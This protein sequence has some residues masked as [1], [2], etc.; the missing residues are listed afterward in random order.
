MTLKKIA[1]RRY[2]D[3]MYLNIY[4]PESQRDDQ[5]LQSCVFLE[6]ATPTTSNEDEECTIAVFRDHNCLQKNA[7]ILKLTHLRRHLPY[8]NLKVPFLKSP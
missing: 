5:P 8:G 7:N 1:L 4:C 3:R 6:Q 2:E